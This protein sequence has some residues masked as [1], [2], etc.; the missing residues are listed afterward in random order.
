M[1]WMVYVFIADGKAIALLSQ[2]LCCPYKP[3]C[4]CK[5]QSFYF[6]LLRAWIW[7]ARLQLRIILLKEAWVSKMSENG[8]KKP[9]SF[10]EPELTPSKVCCFVAT[11]RPGRPSHSLAGHWLMGGSPSLLSSTV[12]RIP[13][14]SR[15]PSGSHAEL[16]RAFW[17]KK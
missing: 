2:V 7:K 5:W 16:F 13:A 10:L 14:R 11:N 1:Y 3:D 8:E 12:P 4:G 6:G 9:M 17:P 15:F